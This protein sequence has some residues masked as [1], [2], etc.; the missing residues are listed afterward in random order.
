MSRTPYTP[1]GRRH[2]Q[3]KRSTES[4]ALIV[5]IVLAALVVVVVGLLVRSAITT[6]QHRLDHAIDGGQQV[7]TAALR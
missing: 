6:A 5:S 1:T 7:R 2:D 4:A 3:R